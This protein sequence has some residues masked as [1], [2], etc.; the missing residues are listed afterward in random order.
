MPLFT[1]YDFITKDDVLDEDDHEEL[2]SSSEEEVEDQEEPD[3]D[4][5]NE[6]PEEEQLPITDYNNGS[7]TVGYYKIKLGSNKNSELFDSISES[8]YDE[9]NLMDE[10]DRE[11]ESF[12]TTH[13]EIFE[14]VDSINTTLDEMLESFDGSDNPYSAIAAISDVLDRN[15]FLLPDFDLDSSVDEWI[16]DIELEDIHEER[17]CYLHLEILKEDDSSYFTRAGIVPV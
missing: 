3:F 12:T 1:I 10:D 5:Y 6:E 2:E 13:E 4:S 15:G 14:E 11:E 7:Y 8:F 16:F 9:E 17:N